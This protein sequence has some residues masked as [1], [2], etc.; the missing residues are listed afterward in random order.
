MWPS[1]EEYADIRR[2]VILAGWGKDIVWSQGLT[3]PATAEVLAQEAIFVI[4]NSGMRFTVAQGI[5]RKVMTALQNGQP[6]RT[7]FG[8]PGKAAAIE[9]IWS[10]RQKLLN[11]FRALPPG[12][13]QVEWCGSLAW[14]GKITK[15][16]LAKNLGV[17]CA[18][19][20]RWLIRIAN[21]SGESVDELCARLHH[22]SQ[23]RIATVD[24]VLWRACA[25]GIVR[26]TDGKASLEALKEA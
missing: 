13:Q 11:E 10:D 4:C 16:H 23:D 15:W 26:I 5:Y 19:P 9:Q 1:D 14:I 6:V 2:R 12:E 7:A 18:K 24:Y 17:D 22:G 3:S 21:V 20:D 25:T 8:H